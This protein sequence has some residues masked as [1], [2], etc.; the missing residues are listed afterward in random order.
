MD[1]NKSPGYNGIH[2]KVL[3]RSISVIAEPLCNIINFAFAKGIFPDSLK[4]AKVIPVFKKGNRSLLTNYRPIS[5]LSV[6]SK[7]FEKNYL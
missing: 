4:V 5:V 1:S 6:F 7:I 3:N 2:P